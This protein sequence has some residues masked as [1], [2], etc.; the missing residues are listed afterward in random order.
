MKSYKKQKDRIT[1]AVTVAMN[2]KVFRPFVI[3]KLKGSNYFKPRSLDIGDHIDGRY[4]TSEKA[5]MTS[6]LFGKY[7][8]DLNKQ[9]G[10]RLQ[11]T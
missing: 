10:Y 8:A 4:F 9:V 6:G 2:G 11:A 1:V 5:W 3:G 7:I